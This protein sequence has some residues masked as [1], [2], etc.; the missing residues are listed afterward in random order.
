MKFIDGIEWSYSRTEYIEEMG[1]SFAEWVERR[2]NRHLT[3][4]IAYRF[5]MTEE[6]APTYASET[7]DGVEYVML[8]SEYNA[9]VRSGFGG[10]YH[11]GVY[12]AKKEEIEWWPIGSDTLEGASCMAAVLSLR[13]STHVEPR[14][15]LECNPG[16][17]PQFTFG[18]TNAS[19][20]IG[21][22][23]AYC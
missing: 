17:Q 9:I 8:P 10:M 19:P 16:G 4:D 20:A 13:G 5:M 6:D 22:L 3:A 18:V 2:P 7:W 23:D 1:S 14:F 15:S 11:G 12:D 21:A